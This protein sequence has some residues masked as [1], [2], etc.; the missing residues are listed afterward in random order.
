[1]TSLLIAA[2]PGMVSTGPGFPQMTVRTGCTPGRCSTLRVTDRSR[3]LPGDVMSHTLIQPSVLPQLQ[4]VVDGR[5]PA[6]AWPC[7]PSVPADQPSLLT[8]AAED[9]ER[10]V[11]VLRNR[12]SAVPARH[13]PDPGAWSASLAC[14]LLETLHG[15]RP[16]AQLSRWVDE[17]VLGAISLHLRRRRARRPTPRPNAGR[18]PPAVRS[19]R[20]QCPDPN[21]VEVTA[22]LLLGQR[23]V[24]MAFRLEACTDRWL[25]TALE[26]GPRVSAAE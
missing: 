10:S 21:A 2:P 26:M 8:V 6:R 19:I 23:S 17:P 15:H 4:P 3:R 11:V 24:A 13:L 12:W 16:A 9:P 18:R 7:P 25:C 1:M 14:A 22:H 20:V 5:P